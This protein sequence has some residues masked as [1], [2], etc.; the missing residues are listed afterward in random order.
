MAVSLYCTQ[1]SSPRRLFHES[2]K[3]DHFIYHHTVK[4][5][6]LNNTIKNYLPMKTT[7]T[8]TTTTTI[9]NQQ[10]SNKEKVHKSF[11]LLS[12][13]KTENGNSRVVI[14]T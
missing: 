2:I 1:S 10:Q 6:Q 7:I 14:S 5:I 4:L 12:N 3:D 8:T 13:Y 11:P 9:T